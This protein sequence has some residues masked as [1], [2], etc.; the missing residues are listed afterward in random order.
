VRPHNRTVAES[1]LDLWDAYR[2]TRGR[3]N[4]RINKVGKVGVWTIRQAGRAVGR[5]KYGRAAALAAWGAAEVGGWMIGRGVGAAATAAVALT[6]TA[7]VLSDKQGPIRGRSVP[8]PTPSARKRHGATVF[9][10]ADRE[11]EQREEREAVRRAMPAPKKAPAPR[12][13]KAPTAE[14]TFVPAA[15][16]KPT[17]KARSTNVAA[18]NAVVEQQQGPRNVAT[19]N[20]V[21][22]QQIGTGGPK[23]KT[24]GPSAGGNVVLGDATVAERHDHLDSS[25]P[26]ED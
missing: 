17:R 18:G 13:K 1:A 24:K 21:V 7:V 25:T 11:D 23:I 22:G 9:H 10:E 8:T 16:P 3:G 4:S 20:A 19:D 26:L 12:P 14:P 6:V 5:R 2:N 15:P